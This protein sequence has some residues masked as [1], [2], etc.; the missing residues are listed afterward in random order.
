M[1]CKLG[2]SN[3]V[4]VP[5]APQG[6]LRDR[7]FQVTLRIS[8]ISW[9]P[10]WA[11]DFPGTSASHAWTKMEGSIF[12]SF[13]PFP[14]PS[15]PL[16]IEQI[17]NEDCEMIGTG[18][19]K[20]PG[21]VLKELTAQLEKQTFINTTTLPNLQNPKRGTGRVEWDTGLCTSSARIK[22][23]EVIGFLGPYFSSPL[24]A[25][26]KGFLKEA[27]FKLGLKEWVALDTLG[28]GRM[29]CFGW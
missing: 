21:S 12:R 2:V 29:G 23:G 11:G 27:A 8:G 20:S 13:H 17:S 28:I 16:I 22:Q 14:P 1:V 24:V 19:K 3:V 26:R 5:A 15:I 18:K 4:L 10:L 9:I 25:G 6:I 7:W